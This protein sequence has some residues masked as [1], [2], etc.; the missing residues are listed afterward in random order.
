MSFNFIVDPATLESYSIF[1]KQGV[2]LLKKYVKEYQTGGE[3][4]NSKEDEG[5]EEDPEE[6]EGD[7]EEEEGEEG[8]REE[9]EEDDAEAEEEE[10][11]ETILN[12]V[13]SLV[14]EQRN[15]TETA[16]TETTLPYGNEED[17]VVDTPSNG[18]DIDDTA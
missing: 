3:D 15:S 11:E 10:G 12:R 17:E 7:P 9:E 14:C 18:G 6:E 16:E 5:E 13:R 1:S 4:P 2:A 8:E